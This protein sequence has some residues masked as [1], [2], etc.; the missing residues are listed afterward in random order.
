MQHANIDGRSGFRVLSE[1]ELTAVSGGF[2]QADTIYSGGLD[3][4][5]YAVAEQFSQTYQSGWVS[6]DPFGDGSP[7]IYDR[8]PS[9]G[10]DE[11][12]TDRERAFSL[13]LQLFG[14]S[15]PLAGAI[16][17]ATGY[18][19]STD[20]K[21]DFEEFMDKAHELVK[22]T[23]FGPAPETTGDPVEDIRRAMGPFGGPKFPEM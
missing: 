23:L 13:T 17:I 10:I 15:A 12:L 14:V 18:L 21:L 8:L 2:S 3:D 1:N 9:E 22:E 7:S 11:H 4:F 16:A 5:D 6:P 19:S 20:A